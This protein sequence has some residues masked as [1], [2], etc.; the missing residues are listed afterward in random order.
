M[1]RVYSHPDPA[2]TH[3]VH[4]ALEQAG[5][6]TLVKGTRPGAA[7]GEIPPIAAWS[8]VWVADPA[9]LGEA[10]AI[11][12]EVHAEPEADVPDQTCGQCGETTEAQFAVC[13]SCGAEM[14]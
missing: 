11:V 1:T 14:V 2:I 9:R 5:I 13:W 8:E 6:P 7:L 4:N 3:L 10:E 12:A